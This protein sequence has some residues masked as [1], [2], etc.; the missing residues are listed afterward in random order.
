MTEPVLSVRGLTTVLHLHGGPV[1]VVRDVDIDVSAGETVALVGESGCGKSMTMLSVMGL[2]PQPPAEIV[3]GRVVLDGRDLL[4]MDEDER[5]AVRGAQLA[6]VYQDPMT[7]LN[8]L[9]RIGDQIGRGRRAPHRS[10][11]R[12]A[13][14]GS[15]TSSG[16]GTPWPAAP[17]ARPAARPRP[18]PAGRGRRARPGRAV[19]PPAGGCGCRP[20][21]AASSST[22]RS[23]TRRRGRRSPRPRRR[24]RRLGRGDR[25]PRRR[26]RL[27]Q[28]DDDAVGDGPAPAAARGDRQRPSSTT[29]PLTISAGGCGAGPSP[30][31]SS[32]CRSLT[33]RR[34]RRSP[35]RRQRRHRRLGRGDRR[36]RR[37]V[38]LRQV[39]DD[40]VGDGPAPAAARGD[41]QRPGRARRPRPAGDGRGRAAGRAGG[42]AGH[43][44]PGPDDVA[45]PADADRRPDRRGARAHDRSRREAE[46]RTVEVL[47]EVG[48]PQPA[49]AARAYPHEFSGGMRQRVVIAMALALRPKVLIADEPTTALDVTIQQ[50]IIALV[51]ALQEHMAMGVVWVTHDLGV[52]A[53]VAERSMVM[54][55]GRIVEVGP[56]AAVFRRPEHPYT[57]GLLAAIPPVKGVE[58]HALRQIPGAP[59]E[60]GRALAGC[61]F[62]PRCPN[63]RRAVPERD[64]AA[65]RPRGQSCRLLGSAGRVDRPTGMT[66]IDAAVATRPILAASGSHQGVSRARL[67]PDVAAVAGVSLSLAP[68]ARRSASSASRAAASPR[69]PGCSSGSRS[70]RRAGSSSTGATSPRCGRAASGDSAAGCSWS[71]RT[72][73]PRSTRGSPSAA[74]STRCC[75]STASGAR[76][77][78]KPAGRRAAR[79]GRP[80]GRSGRPLP[81]PAVRRAAPARRHRPRPRRRARGDRARRAAVVAR[82]LGPVGDHEP[83]HRPPRR[84]RRRL[85][86][87]LP[88]PRHGAPHLRPHRRDVPRAGGRARAVG[89]RCRT[90]RSTRTRW[91]CSRPCRSPTPTSRPPARSRRS[92]ARSPTR[93]TRPQGARST[94]AARWPRTCAA[95]P[96]PSLLELERDHEVACHVAARRFGYVVIQ[97]AEKRLRSMTARSWVPVLMVWA[98]PRLRRRR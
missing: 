27:R 6:M 36:P 40:A 22:C 57:A 98:E 24:C 10:G 33:R 5:R 64:A 66:V 16:P 9:M 12:S 63:T 62:E 82:R 21:T 4:A 60:P 29:R 23:L 45:E 47:A 39:D 87:H 58:R 74:R 32:T 61:P 1:E 96:A 11:R 71:S 14:T 44:V 50:Q 83:A 93:R 54:Y 26:V 51:P 73:T 34:G 85:R 8:P 53:R 46:A 19:R 15:A 91:R 78:A 70:R 48:L 84:A 68:R 41:R 75:A 67:R 42:A 30:A 49:R 86:V 56:T 89:R 37:R 79:H 20:I 94:P 95:S 17:P 97:V 76:D 80:A 35:R 28:V 65:D 69:S 38:R 59:P 77:A 43:G 3:S 13:L 90:A 92:A 31:S 7:S 2:H 72:R 52:V 88:R 18:S 81:A 55:G 25:R